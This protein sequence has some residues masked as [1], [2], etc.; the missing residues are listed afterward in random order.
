ML[1]DPLEDK[2]CDRCFEF[3]TTY[4][5]IDTLLAT[6]DTADFTE[7]WNGTRC[8]SYEYHTTLWGLNPRNCELCKIFFDVQHDYSRQGCFGVGSGRRDWSRPRTFEAVYC[9]KKGAKP[10]D[11]HQIRFREVID[12]GL[13]PQSSRWLEICAYPGTHAHVLLRCAHHAHRHR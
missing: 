1:T 3:L 5:D 11:F 6:W 13:R 10:L 8:V 2:F 12:H 9:V 7:E 4:P